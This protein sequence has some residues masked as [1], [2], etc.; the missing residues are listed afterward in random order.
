MVTMIQ[1]IIIKVS[2]HELDDP[3]FLT[4]FATAVKA[5]TVPVVIVHGGGAEISSLHKTMGIEPRFLD[6]V[7]ITDA[8]SL[9]VAEMVMA[10]TVNKRLVRYL[11]AAGVDAQGMSG[12]DRGLVRAAKMQHPT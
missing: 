10:G 5:Q 4:E 1:P 11:L 12:I 9:K 7:R 8:A 6:G 3:N 2:G